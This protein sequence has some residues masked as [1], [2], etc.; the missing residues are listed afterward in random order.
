MNAIYVELLPWFQGLPAWQNEAF[1]RI[2]L[3]QKLE[4]GDLN[5]I[6]AIACAELGLSEKPLPVPA[7]IAAEEFPAAAAAKGG[8][9]TLGSIHSCVNVNML[10]GGMKLDFG[11][12]LTI[13]YGDNGV[14]KSGY[15]RVLKRACRCNERAI[16]KILSNVYN[17]AVGDPAGATFEVLTDKASRTIIWQDGSKPDRE[18]Q[19]LAIFDSKAA[20]AYLAERNNLPVVPTVFVQLEAFGEAVRTVKDRLATAAESEQPQANALAGFVD[21]SKFGQAI[22]ALNSATNVKDLGAKLAWTE[23]DTAL[24][25]D[26]DHQLAVMKTQGPDALRKALN[27]RRARIGTLK[28]LIQSAERR[29]APSAVEAIKD[30]ST[31]CR[32]LKQQKDAAAKLA[33]GESQI[34]GVG[35]S[36]WEE[37]VRSAA[38]FFSSIDHEG[39]FPGIANTSRCVLCQQLI[40]GEAH[41]R[42]RS[43]WAFL[44]NDASVKLEAESRVL[45]GLIEE[46]EKIPGAVPAEITVNTDLFS[47]E[48]PA[49]WPNVAPQFEKLAAIRSGVLSAIQSGD[50]SQIHSM[51]ESLAA[52][53]DI[54]GNALEGKVKVLGDSA[55]AEMET[56][57]LIER[58]A[59]LNCRKRA[60]SGRNAIIQHCQRLA[61]AQA[62]RSAADG[63]STFSISNKASS[64]QDRY[65]I[66]S[67]SKQVQEESKQLGLRRAIPGIKSKTQAGKVSQSVVIGGAKQPGVGPDVVFS[68]GE[69]TALALAYFLSELGSPDD[70]FGVVLDDPVTSLDHRIRSKVVDRIVKLSEERQVI[71]FTHDLPF[72]CELRDSATWAGRSPELRSVEAFGGKVGQIRNGEPL[73]AMNVASRELELEGLIKQAK[74]FE[75][76]DKKQEYQSICS[77]YYSLMRSTWERAVEEL[78][79]N[80]VVQRFDK[81]VKTM[82]LIGVSVDDSVITEVHAGMTKGSEL[83]DAHD[84]ALATGT[85][86]PDAAEM[87]KDLVKLT[88]FRVAQ[89]KRSNAQSAKLAHLK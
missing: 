30:S 40:T 89:K 54:E 28:S 86:F 64:L 71:V 83:T 27:E 47:A 9:V 32:Q 60:F 4:A 76:A 2:R 41:N 8:R 55:K 14:G 72:F 48:V 46:M 75:D 21:G 36:A 53:C 77:R 20:K 34:K 69:R 65:V 50:W 15:A 35:S 12:G 85:S 62:L 31:R 6:Y 70:T 7:K 19:R 67:F 1:R 33:F 5:E 39:S 45:A 11:A 61:R 3:R 82:R 51:E 58:I 52:V 81:T 88:E 80:Q 24:L 63:I 73:E 38:A 49:I 56:Q 18:L 74:V 84:H 13:V 10:A 25:K 44:Q 68:E 22:A 78:V 23:A 37:L 17:P 16:E 29:A 87:R 66:D 43:F 42:L 59:D 57:A 26:L 79:F